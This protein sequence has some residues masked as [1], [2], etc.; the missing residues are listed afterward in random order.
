MAAPEDLVV[1]RVRDVE[2][3]IG[4]EIRRGHFHAAIDL[5]V[6][7]KQTLSPQKVSSSSSSSQSSVVD[8]LKACVTV[9]CMV[10]CMCVQFKDLV[11]EYLEHLMSKGEY[12]QAAAECPRLLGDDVEQWEM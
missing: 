4:W 8:S 6:Q 7:S 2:D 1:A 11:T 10:G 3:V 9:R 5:A 12:Q